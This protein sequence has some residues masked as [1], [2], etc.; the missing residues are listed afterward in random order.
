MWDNGRCYICNSNRDDLNCCATCGLCFE[1]DFDLYPLSKKLACHTT[2]PPPYS[3]KSVLQTLLL[4]TYDENSTLYYLNHH[5][6]T[7]LQQIWLVVVDNSLY[8]AKYIQQDSKKCATIVI[9]ESVRKWRTQARYYVTFPTPKDININMM[10]FLLNKRNSLSED[11]RSYW[12]IIELCARQL[13]KKYRYDVGCI[14]YLTIQESLVLQ[15]S[16]QRRPGLHTE[17]PGYVQV[18]KDV[19]EWSNWGC[20]YRTDTF[21]GGIF[22]ATSVSDSCRIWDNCNILPEAIKNGGNIEHLRSLL[23]N[24]K[25]VKKGQLWWMSDTSPHES[26]PLLEDTYRQFF[27]LVVGPVSL[28]FSD[29]STPN[30]LGTPIGENCKVIHGNKFHLFPTK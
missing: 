19:Y 21:D 22:I 4:G 2:E 12:P 11:Y 26:L 23:G 3:Y 7:L 8:Y 15:G 18:E 24:G 17:S 10:P 30:P 29:H 6:E 27:R 5:R 9:S 20:G 16:S 1:R 13:E 28:W 25:F 14:A